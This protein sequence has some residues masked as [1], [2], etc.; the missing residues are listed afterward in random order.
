[1]TL[2]DPVTFCLLWRM[3][4]VRKAHW[5]C[6]LC[7]R[8]THRPLHSSLP[9][10]WPAGH[11]HSIWCSLMVLFTVPW[12]MLWQRLHFQRPDFSQTSAPALYEARH[13][14]AVS[15]IPPLHSERSLILLKMCCPP[16]YA[17]AAFLSC[18]LFSK[19][20]TSSFPLVASG[21]INLWM[22]CGK[23]LTTHT[24]PDNVAVLPS[25]FDCWLNG[26]SDCQ[27]WLVLRL[28]VLWYYSP[29]L[30]SDMYESG[31][32]FETWNYCCSW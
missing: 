2:L 9:L 12:C 32:K 19:G 4:P 30:K 18:N 6:S 21:I 22:T 8:N 25:I 26:P 11:V 15:L 31:A 28:P 10:G 27:L 3:D 14:N 16:R 13:A 7:Y 23:A 29:A 5:R 17:T 24:F 20:S 1:M